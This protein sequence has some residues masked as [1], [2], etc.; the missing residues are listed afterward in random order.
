M[1]QQFYFDT[2]VKPH[3]VKQLADGAIWKD[4][5]MQFPFKADVPENA[6]FKF[7][8]NDPN[9]HPGIYTVAELIETS[10]LSK[11]GYFIC[12]HLPE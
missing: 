7:A 2:G 9:L 12:P 4:G 8:A 3:N 6:I 5:T 1:L 10:L 11:Y